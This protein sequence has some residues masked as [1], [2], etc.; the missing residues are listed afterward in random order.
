MAKL[1]S[2]PEQRA[3]EDTAYGH[4]LVPTRIFTV[5]L[6]VWRVEIQATVTDAEDYAVID[7]Y[8]ERAIAEGGLDTTPELARFL[9]LDEVIV[10]R[11]LRFLAAIEHVLVANGRFTLTPLGAASVRDQ[12]SYRRS[13]HDRRKL[14]FD[15]FGSRPLTRPYYDSQAV[16][17][18]ERHEAR[19]AVDDV[20]G[21]GFMLANTPA[22][23][24]EALTGLAHATERDTFNLPERIEN[25]QSVGE[26]RVYLP[27]YLVRAARTRQPPRYLAYSQI[28]DESEPYLTSI[29]EN[30]DEI[31]SAC[32]HDWAPKEDEERRR[33]SEWLTRRNL[34][35][36]RPKRTTEDTWSV[37]LPAEAF[38]RDRALGLSQLGSYIVLGNF[39]F[40]TW[41]A[42]ESARRR[43]LV[44]RGNSY[45]ARSGLVA[46]TATK[47]V[48]QMGRQLE[49]G[50]IDLHTLRRWAIAA[51]R[52]E[53]AAQLAPFA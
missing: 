2:Y 41:C 21:R 33:I 34:G 3:L 13:V 6:P 22:F 30:T 45:L 46:D 28:S 47:R 19:R 1:S 14:Y 49:L 37:T 50:D 51:G 29:C 43:A 4:G 26:E 24:R 35:R 42:D 20:A 16:T 17:F 44:E 15:A 11:A 38:G 10:D 40:H 27:L 18:I 39:F 32:E 31:A 23:R 7:R 52:S 5:L 48:K 53:L 25:P 12:K 36:Y 8:L 9:A